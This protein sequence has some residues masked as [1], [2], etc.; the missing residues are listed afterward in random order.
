MSTACGPRIAAASEA[1]RPWSGV[2]WSGAFELAVASRPRSEA[3]EPAA[4]RSAH[5]LEEACRPGAMKPW[6]HG[7]RRGAKSA[8]Q[9]CVRSGALC[10]TVVYAVR[11]GGDEIAMAAPRRGDG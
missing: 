3:V 9:L 10:A 5:R 7:L 11:R 1:S 4:I 8:S 2:E 6:T